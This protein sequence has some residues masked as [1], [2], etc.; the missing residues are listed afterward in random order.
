[1]MKTHNSL[2]CTSPSNHSRNVYRHFSP[3]RGS[4]RPISGSKARRDLIPQ[5]N[6]SELTA[7]L[8]QLQEEFTQLSS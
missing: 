8:L 2:L 5:V 3:S 6:A 7:L 1:M 4:S